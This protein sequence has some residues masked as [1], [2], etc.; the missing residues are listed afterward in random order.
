MLASIGD[1]KFAKNSGQSKRTKKKKQT[2][3]QQIAKLVAKLLSNLHMVIKLELDCKLKAIQRHRQRQR[4]R[5]SEEAAAEDEDALSRWHLQ[6]GA[7]LSHVS[8]LEEFQLESL[9]LQCKRLQM[10]LRK[11]SNSR[12]QN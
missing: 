11:S 12:K 2:K 1:F 5:E 8:K 10:G 9:S 6:G 7:Y 4:E 3:K